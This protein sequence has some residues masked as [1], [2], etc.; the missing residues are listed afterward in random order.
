MIN[1]WEL[2]DWGGGDGRY[3]DSHGRKPDSIAVA[4]EDGVAISAKAARANAP[5]DEVPRQ[6]PPMFCHLT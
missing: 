4:G 2:G 6:G 3:A 5:P 1:R